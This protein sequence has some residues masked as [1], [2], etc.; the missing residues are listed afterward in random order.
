MFT[1]CFECAIGHFQI[2][3]VRAWVQTLKFMTLDITWEP[4][5]VRSWLIAFWKRE[6]IQKTMENI[7]LSFDH[8]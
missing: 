8:F 2:N 5:I 6:C 4:L 3:D 1:L 7:F